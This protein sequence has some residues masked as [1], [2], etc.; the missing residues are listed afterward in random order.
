MPNDA[1]ERI[2]AY[3]DGA[4]IMAFE[5]ETTIGGAVEFIRSDLHAELLAENERLKA[6]QSETQQSL[7]GGI[8]GQKPVEWATVR[9]ED[10]CDG[11]IIHPDDAKKW[12][13]IEDHPYEGA[14]LPDGRYRI[15][16]TRPAEQSVTDE[17]L[18]RLI[19]AINDQLIEADVDY[20]AG[21][22]AG[23]SISYDDVKMRVALTAALAQK[24]AE[25]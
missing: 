2:W 4:H 5:Y 23:H 25:G 12:S 6:A 22:R 7:S 9:V 19:D 20:P 14:F 10:T 16:I 24:D 15:A 18:D 8:D 13:L 11:L 1:P 21:E 3:N 17:T